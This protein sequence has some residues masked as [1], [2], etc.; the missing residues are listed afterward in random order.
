[1]ILGYGLLSTKYHADAKQV[2]PANTVNDVAATKQPKQEEKPS[3]K[4]PKTSSMPKPAKP[5]S[6]AVPLTAAAILEP[7][8]MWFIASPTSTA[9]A[10]DLADYAASRLKQIASSGLQPLAVIEPVDAYGTTLD[11]NAYAAGSYDRAFEAFYGALKSRGITDETM[12]MW[13]LLPEANMPEWGNSDPATISACITRTAQI[14]KKHFP[15]SRAT[16]LFNS[17]TYPGNDTSYSQGGYKSLVP[18][19]A[20]IPKGLIDSFGYQGFP[21]AR[22]ANQPGPSSL[23]PAEYLR[24]DLAI[25]AAR[26]LGVQAVWVNTGSFA[27]MYANDAAARVTLSAEQ[28]QAMLQGALEQSKAI[29]A[30]NLGVAVHMFMEDKSSTA[31]ATDWSFSRD[32]QLLTNF[33]QQ[34]SQNKL[35]YWWYQ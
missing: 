3:N 8:Q 25:E 20:N 21:W 6:V 26:A 4:K 30:G 31:E 11:L 12:G 33:K 17:Q 35:G 14:Q 27:R 16:V 15:A 22:A 1:M 5:A 32:P 34:L 10:N 13:T 29:R 28:R 23:N 19:V 2:L 7:R 9:S 24:P 18:Y